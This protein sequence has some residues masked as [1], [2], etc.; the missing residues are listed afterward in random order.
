MDCYQLRVTGMTQLLASVEVLARV[1][2]DNLVQ[3]SS[4]GILLTYII[5]ALRQ[6]KPH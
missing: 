2:T 6:F 3:V 1:T 5:S 4:R